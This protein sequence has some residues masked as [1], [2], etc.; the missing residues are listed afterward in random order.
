[1]TKQPPLKLEQLETM[2]Y[3]G[4]HQQGAT[5]L[6]KVLQDIENKGLSIVPDEKAE[7]G[8]REH[9]QLQLNTRLAA[10]ITTLMANKSFS[11]SQQGYEV[12]MVFKRFMHAVFMASGFGD[13]NHLLWQIAELDNQGQHQVHGDGALRKLLLTVSPNSP[14]QKLKYDGWITNFP[15]HLSLPFWLSFIDAEIVISRQAAEARKHIA[16]LCNDITVPDDYQ[17]PNGMITRLSNAWMF[18]SYM[19]FPQKHHIKPFLNRLV[20]RF[21]DQN[22][23]KAP[24][25]A[26]TPPKAPKGTEKPRLLIASEH[27][28]SPHAMHR[29]YRPVIESLRA[30]FYTICLC[31]IDTIDETGREAFDE[32]HTFK[33]G[34]S[35]RK[36][37]GLVIK[38]KPDV[39]YYPSLGMQ[40]W[41]LIMAQYRFAPLQ[42][43]TLGHPATSMLDT[44]DWVITEEALMG[45]PECFY[46]KILLIDKIPFTD[47]SRKANYEH[48]PSSNGE[49]VRIAVNAKLYKINHQLITMCQGLAKNAKAPVEFHF[50]PACRGLTYEAFSREI[51]LYIESAKVYPSM[52]YTNYIEQLRECD[53]ALN[54]FPFGNTNGIADCARIGLPFVCMDGEEVHSYTDAALAQ[55]L[56]YSDDFVAQSLDE[57]T[58]KALAF[59]NNSEYR[60]TISKSLI[61]NQRWTQLFTGPDKLDTEFGEAVA[62]LYRNQEPLSHIEH[63]CWYRKDWQKGD[64]T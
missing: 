5:A 3:S 7:A 63:R 21:G 22:G 27:F 12:F 14:Q 26:S 51:K 46:E 50:F 16:L 45:N 11:L 62:W 40:D 32:V 59:I 18:C 20:R 25:T 64:L 47:H 19:D 61:Q 23:I 36:I 42:L 15:L 37:A 30:Y 10:C 52:N 29:C 49:P 53:F 9:Q 28:R 41:T 6:L 4:D 1:M 2:I 17:M 39:I 43:M 55:R 8:L 54:P 24:A 58:D 57:Y 31:R 38:T 34:E 33:T 48:T 44:I 56:G 13:M 35:I 60:Q